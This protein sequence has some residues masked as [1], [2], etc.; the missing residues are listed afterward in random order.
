MVHSLAVAMPS[1]K[2]KCDMKLNKL[3]QECSGI[4]FK[5]TDGKFYL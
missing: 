2:E 4:E 1:D 3:F 5:V